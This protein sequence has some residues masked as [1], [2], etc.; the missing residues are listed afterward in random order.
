MQFRY[1][2]L[3]F[4]FVLASCGSSNSLTQQVDIPKIKKS[5]LIKL[6]DANSFANAKFNTVKVNSKLSY[7]IGDTSQKLGLK[8][9]IAKGQKLWMSADFLGIPVAKLL[10]EKDSVHYYN[11]IDKTYFEGSFELL[12]ELTGL[13]FSYEILESLFTGDLAINLK[14]GSYRMFRGESDYYFK[15]SNFSDYETRVELYPTTYKVKSQSITNYSGKNFLAAFYKEYKEVDSFV[16][17]KD[18]EIRGLNNEKS[19]LISLSYTSVKFDEDLRF[20]FEIPEDCDKEIVL[21]TTK[22]KEK[23]NE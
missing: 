9:R 7:K 13:N 10:V 8:I 17:P 20:P 6:Y 18:F 1:L 15:N 16:F 14:N 19:S 11:K 21:K 4:L 3:L 22:A 2:A 23:T 5:K 12:K